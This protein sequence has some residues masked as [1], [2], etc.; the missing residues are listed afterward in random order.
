M[1]RL[2]AISP[3]L[4]TV[5]W[6]LAAVSSKTLVLAEPI[7]QP[8]APHILFS[9]EIADLL[10]HPSFLEP[11]VL[12]IKSRSLPHRSAELLRPQM[13]AESAPVDTE[14]QQIQDRLREIQQPQKPPVEFG[15]LT[16]GS[17]GLSVANPTGFGADGGSGAKGVSLFSSGSFQQRTR[18][19]K[20]DKSDGG[21]GFGLG[22][23]DAAKAVG[24]EVS[25][26]V[27]SFGGSRDFGAGGLNFKIHHRINEDLSVAIGGNGVFTT[28][29]SVDFGGSY[30]G[31][32][33]KIVRTRPSLCKPFSRVA[34]NGGLGNGQF[35][36]QDDI[37]KDQNTVGFF[38]GVAVRVFCPVS[39]LVEWTGQD[40]ATG[41]SLAPPLP[42][43][44]VKFAI[45]PA[46]RDIVG[47]GDG[48]RFIISAGIS[49]QLP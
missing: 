46:I 8:P 35:R 31:A 40:L 26:T 29:K 39:I 42:T 2:A 34:L 15:G 5:L 12:S 20:P 21:I 13:M 33:T 41:L 4:T 1:R 3:V 47:A 38:G 30:Y 44:K 16:L 48:P 17:P 49:F 43:R 27:A 6:V 36:T 32:V 45:T 18:F 37:V 10:S 25:Y 11:V 24:A 19:S 23:G 9:P 14:L 7:A 22:F 28:D